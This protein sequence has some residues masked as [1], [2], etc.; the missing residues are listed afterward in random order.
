VAELLVFESW[1]KVGTAGVLKGELG[2]EFESEFDFELDFE[3][4]EFS[5]DLTFLIALGFA[6]SPIA[7]VPASCRC[8]ESS[9]SSIL[10]ES[11][12]KFKLI[13][14]DIGFWNF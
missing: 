13:V 5:R 8:H 10:S 4:V 14:Q 1:L 12:K 9:P 3:F 2:W 7:M 6:S 11:S